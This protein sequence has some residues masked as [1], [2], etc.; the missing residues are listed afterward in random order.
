MKPI[1]FYSI[2]KVRNQAQRSKWQ[3][4]LFSTG[5]STEEQKPWWM[6]CGTRSVHSGSRC[7]EASPRLGLQM[8]PPGKR[9]KPITTRGLTSKSM[10]LNWQLAMKPWIPLGSQA[11]SLPFTQFHMRLS[12][13]RGKQ[14]H[15][16]CYKRASLIL[17][18]RRTGTKAWK[19][20][21]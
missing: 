3:Q 11:K 12:A 5:K 20:G 8:M 17:L 14:S 9:T 7:R 21:K 18:S 2:A 10:A 1:A 4:P 13:K 19:V 16:M 15:L 6:T